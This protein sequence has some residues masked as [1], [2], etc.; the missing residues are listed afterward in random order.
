[1]RDA[2]Y[3]ALKVF[4]ALVAEH[5]RFHCQAVIGY[6]NSSLLTFRK[7]KRLGIACI[8][9][10]TSVHHTLQERFAP[11]SNR[12]SWVHDKDQEIELADMILTC[13]KLAR[14]SYIDAG[15]PRTKVVSSMLGVDISLFKNCSDVRNGPLVFCNAGSIDS[16]KGSDLIAWACQALK[17]RGELFEFILAGNTLG[18][19][20]QLIAGLQRNASIRPRMEQTALPAFYSSADVFILPSRFDSFGMVVLEALACGV[21]V[22]VTENVGSKDVIEEGVNGW[23]IRANDRDALAERMAWCIR[24][25]ESVRRMKSAARESAEKWSWKRYRGEVSSQLDQFMASFSG[26]QGIV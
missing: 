7:A 8:L 26:R 19:D 22:I 21:P 12:A 17:D 16:K 23:V 6:E 4:D 18:L 3:W 14:D 9:D 25:P 15:V 1:V 13:S 20:Q 2:S 5:L 24:N 11:G 10:A